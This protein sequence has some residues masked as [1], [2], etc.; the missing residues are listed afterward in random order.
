MVPS[1]IKDSLNIHSTNSDGAFFMTQA[2]CRAL[3]IWMQ[4]RHLLWT[5]V[6]EV[7]GSEWIRK[8]F[9]MK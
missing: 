4:R 9:L 6:M 2:L 1:K 8:G 3:Q 5:L 7:V